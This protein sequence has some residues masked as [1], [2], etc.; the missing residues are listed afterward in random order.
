MF[1]TSLTVF[2]FMPRL[3]QSST[4]GLRPSAGDTAGTLARKTSTNG[5]RTVILPSFWRPGTTSMRRGTM[6]FLYSGLNV[7]C[8]VVGMGWTETTL[9]GGWFPGSDVD[10]GIRSADTLRI[11]VEVDDSTLSKSDTESGMVV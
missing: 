8:D 4:G 3:I 5:F 1:N 10:F 6:Y 7:D 2:S 11:E 9:R